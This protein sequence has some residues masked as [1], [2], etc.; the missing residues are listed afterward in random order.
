MNK[1]EQATIDVVANDV[2]W[3]KKTLNDMDK[4]F[5]VALDT[6]DTRITNVSRR[7]WMFLGGIITIAAL[8]GVFI[9]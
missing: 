9:R 5:K 4:E 8:Y 2:K 3:I 6:H 7:T 1:K